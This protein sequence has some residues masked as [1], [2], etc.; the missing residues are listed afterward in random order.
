M[1]IRHICIN[2]VYAGNLITYTYIY[3]CHH[4]CILSNC[5]VAIYKS[6][7][8]GDS[9]VFGIL[10]NG[11]WLRAKF[12]HRKSV[13]CKARADEIISRF[14]TLCRNP[15]ICIASLT[16]VSQVCVCE[17]VSCR[18]HMTYIAQGATYPFMRSKSALLDG[19]APIY[20]IRIATEDDLEPHRGSLRSLSAK[21]AYIKWSL[22]FGH[23]T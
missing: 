10:F 22:P 9:L 14:S 16:T 7:I 23:Y 11:F 3:T 20:S 13:K 19:G 21:T 6:V 2:I 4:T 18:W 15:H 17:R 8:D 1:C 12:G 5:L